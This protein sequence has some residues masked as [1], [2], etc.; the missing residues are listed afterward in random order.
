[1]MLYC[2]YNTDDNSLKHRRSGTGLRV[3]DPSDLYSA[4]ETSRRVDRRSRDQDVR[5]QV[6]TEPEHHFDHGY[7]VRNF[8]PILFDLIYRDF[9]GV[10]G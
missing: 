4:R 7:Q 6:F 5:H 8:S 1:M 9:S 10:V 3:T 2:V